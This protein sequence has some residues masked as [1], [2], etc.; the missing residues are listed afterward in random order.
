MMQFSRNLLTFG[1]EGQELLKQATVAILGL[2]GVGSF[3]CEAIVRSG[4]GRIILIDKD[5]VDITNINRQLHATLETVGQSK[6]DLMAQRI[7][8]IN[9]ECEVVKHD[10]FFNHDTY[11]EILNDEISFFIDACDTITYKILLIKE[12]LKRKIPFIS[13][14]GAANKLDP[15]MFEI[16]DISETSY[17]PIAKVIRTKLRKEKITGK[18]PVVYS[19][20]RPIKPKYEESLE[21]TNSEIRKTQFPPASNSFV[22]PVAG[23][24]AASYAIRYLIKDIEIR[25]NGDLG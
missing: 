12:C 25:R 2:G 20:E 13:V 18:I 9:P 1:K 7:K 17:D 14:M 15:T 19:K 21:A 3:S 24:I 4:V 8:A 10:K 5:K 23:F 6:V 22:P 11:E 16:A